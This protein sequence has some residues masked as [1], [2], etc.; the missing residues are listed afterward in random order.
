MEEHHLGVVMGKIQC[1]KRQCRN[2]RARQTWLRAFRI[3]FD[4]EEGIITYA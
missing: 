3:S 4:R 1:S 2:V